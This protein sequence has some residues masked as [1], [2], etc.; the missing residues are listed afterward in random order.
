MADVANPIR[1][2]LLDSTGDLDTTG[3]DFNFAAGS[4]GVKQGIQTGLQMFLAECY[5]DQSVGIDWLGQI[6]VK[7][8]DPLV[9]RELLT[10]RILAVPDVT[11]AIGT[12]VLIADRAG[13]VNYQVADVYSVNPVGGLAQVQT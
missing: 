8:P 11:T 2:F 5:L 10:E 9:V 1:D 4:V 13:S 3:G 12:Q 7:N 6:L